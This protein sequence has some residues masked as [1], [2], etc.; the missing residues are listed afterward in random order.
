MI[1]IHTNLG[2]DIRCASG[3]V[4]QEGIRLSLMLLGRMGSE[5]GR[6]QSWDRR[7]QCWF[8]AA[9]EVKVWDRSWVEAE[10]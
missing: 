2:R 3:L 10:E 4:P 1:S 8:R 5:Y 6:G 9:V 7:K